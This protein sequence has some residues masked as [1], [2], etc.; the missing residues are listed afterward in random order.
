VGPLATGGRTIGPR[1]RRVI[2]LLPAALLAA[3]VATGAFVR[4]SSL[5]LDART[6]GLAVALL[7]VLRRTGVVTVLVVAAAS[8]ALFRLAGL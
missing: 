1:A 2:A 6:A 7:L 3:L 8:T 5:I 4:G